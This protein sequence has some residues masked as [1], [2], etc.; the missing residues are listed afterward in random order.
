MRHYFAIITS[1]LTVLALI[2]GNLV[3]LTKAGDA[4]GTDWPTCNGQLIPDFSNYKIAIEYSHRIFT[5]SLGFVLL[6]NAVIAWK[7][8]YV[9]ET[10]VK[11]FTILSLLL[12]LVQSGVGGLNVL[13]GTP[14]GFTTIDVTVSLLLLSSTVILA[15]VLSR[16]EVNRLG[17][18]EKSKVGRYQQL[19]KP[20]MFGFSLYFL[21]V[22][23]GAFFKHSGASKMVNFITT[24]ETLINSLTL[25]ETLYS[26]H[27]I[28]NTIILVSSGYGLF[29]AW[30]H[31]VLVK[32]AVIFF[33]FILLNGVT[34]FMTQLSGLYEIVSSL[35][36]IVVILT[37]FQGSYLVATA[38]FSPYFVKKTR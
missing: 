27:G 12:L 6:V 30:K 26:V 15:V 37:V 14:P 36:M 8:K 16:T 3:V 17:N 1:Y 11:L 34:G 4:C 33:L 18:D 29:L 23:I 13:L 7:R 20:L 22:L 38:Y 9:G 25:S 5:G 19:F 21:E 32:Q 24:D 28:A 31:E 10:E 2:I 35:H